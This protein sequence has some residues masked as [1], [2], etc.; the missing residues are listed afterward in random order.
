MDASAPSARCVCPRITPGCSSNVF[1]TRSSNSRIR[2]ICVNIQMSRSFDRPFSDTDAPF[3]RE[4]ELRARRL[5]RSV[6][7]LLDRKAAEVLGEDLDTPR[8]LVAQLAKHG[9]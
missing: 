6:E 7:D 9:D 4:V 1:F 8:P 5:V 2:V 3:S